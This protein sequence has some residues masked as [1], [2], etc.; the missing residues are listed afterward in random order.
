MCVCCVLVDFVFVYYIL[1]CVFFF[2]INLVVCSVCF[3]F[4]FSF[5]EFYFCVGVDRSDC[6]LSN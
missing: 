5:G 2:C 6:P 4:F 1:L 3:D